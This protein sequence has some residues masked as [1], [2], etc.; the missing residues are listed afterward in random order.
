MQSANTASNSSTVSDSAITYID[1]HP[2][3]HDVVKEVLAG[4]SGAQ[5]VLSPKYFYDERGSQLFEAITQQPEYYPT[6]TE[7]KILTDNAGNIADLI[8]QNITLIEP[9]CGSCEKV[10]LLLNALQPHQFIAMDISAEFLLT[11]TNAL[12]EE[13]PSLDITAVCAD[14]SQITALTHRLNDS[15]NEHRRVA[16][17]PGSTLGNFHPGAALDFLSTVRQMVGSNGGLLI[18]VDRHKNAGILDAAY[19]DAKGVTADFNLNALTHINRLLP[20]NFNNDTF[21]HH[22]FYNSAQQRIEMHLRSET[23]QVVDC[24]SHA[25]NFNANETIHSE[26]SYKYTPEQ[27]CALAQTAGFKVIKTWSDCDDLFSVYYC[28]AQ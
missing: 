8:G 26:N 4:F 22:A 19:N 18:G 21:S 15:K 1:M 14:F 2:P 24:A 27:F 10:R 17:Y 9:G 23:K 28:A 7:R 25:I 11:A 13:Y 20:A 6:R 16:F 12:A 5:K 3:R